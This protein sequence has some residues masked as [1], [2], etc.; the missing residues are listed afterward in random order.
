MR[1]S[2][3]VAVAL[4]S[5]SVSGLA[6]QNNTY[7]AKPSHTEKAPRSSVPVSKTAMGPASTSASANK[8]LKSLE[9]QTAQASAP[10]RSAGRGTPGKAPALKPAKTKSNP[11][12]NFNGSGGGGKSA[13]MASQGTNPYKGRLRQKDRQK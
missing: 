10:I 7:K 9:H 13:G 11:P 12:I 2:L 4:A 5:L 3:A 6:Q 1:F 8:D